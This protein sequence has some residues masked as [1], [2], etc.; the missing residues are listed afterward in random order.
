MSDW[1]ILIFRNTHEVIK[2]D[3]FLERENIKREVIPT[4]KFISSECGLCIKVWKD[5][6]DVV[7]ILKEGGVVPLKIADSSFK[8]IWKAEGKT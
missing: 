8:E 1:F 7:K 6:S 4:P 3:A 2:A 5:I